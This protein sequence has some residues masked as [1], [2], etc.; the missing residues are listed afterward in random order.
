MMFSRTTMA[1]SMSRPIASESPS[2]VIMLSEKPS[3]VHEE[4]GADDAGRQRDRR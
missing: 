2:S 1:S 4:E 3:S